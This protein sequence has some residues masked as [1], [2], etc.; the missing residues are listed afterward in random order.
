[1]LLPVILLLFAVI[2]VVAVALHS[3]VRPSIT[4]EQKMV[5]MDLTPASS[6]E[7]TTNH[8]PSTPVDM[9]PIAGNETPY[10]VNLYQ[11]YM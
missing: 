1:M 10:R 6:Y 8:L 2:T 9:G 4:R 3:K 11:G 5:A 7:Q